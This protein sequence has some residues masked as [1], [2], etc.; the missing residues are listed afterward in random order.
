MANA[1]VN[2]S[3]APSSGG[4]TVTADAPLT[5][6]GSSGSHL[7]ISA[8]T[9]GAA[10]SQ[11]AAGKT[12][13]TYLA[14]RWENVQE[15]FLA[16]K[17]SGLTYEYLKFGLTSSGIAIASVNGDANIAGGALGAQN[18]AYVTFGT[19]AYPAMKTA[20]F[21][22]CFRSKILLTGGVGTEIGFTDVGGTHGVA[23]VTAPGADATHYMSLFKN[24]GTSDRV[25][26][27]FVA[28]TAHHDFA[29]VF[30]PGA[31]TP[32]VSAYIDGVNVLDRTTL[33][34]LLDG[35]FMFYVYG[36][37]ANQAALTKLVYGFV[38]P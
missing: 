26:T 10:G 36:G 4:G 1:T 13:E 37:S 33:T 15:A 11:S 20:K 23:F 19:V 25:S 35:N 38:P 6:D 12:L 28:D 24:G 2:Y 16:S 8:A 31:A 32:T 29:M 7:A 14:G 9:T 27:S 30:D 22:F 3:P 18:A 5:G 21:G 34:N 17:I